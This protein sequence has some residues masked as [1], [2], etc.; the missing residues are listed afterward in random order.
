MG[1]LTREAEE[2]LRTKEAKKKAEDLITRI[3]PISYSKAGEIEPTIKKSLSARGE[4]V[5]TRGRT[6]SS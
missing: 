3:I 5:V 6:R 2:E 1:A 4:T